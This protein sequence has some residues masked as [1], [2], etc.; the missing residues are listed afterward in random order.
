MIAGSKINLGEYPGSSK[1][2]EQN[3]D[4]RKR[5]LVLDGNLIEGS[6]VHAQS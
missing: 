3:I 1:F 5:I 4:P 2:I 6:I